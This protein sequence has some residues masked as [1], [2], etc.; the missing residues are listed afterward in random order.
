MSLTPRYSPSGPVLP[1]TPGGGFDPIFRQLWLDTTKAPGGNGS[2][3]TPYNTWAAAVA[4]LQASGGSNPWVIY[5]AQEL[6]ATGTP[7][8]NIGAGGH[9]TPLVKLQGTVQS[10]FYAP[11]PTSLLGLVISAQDGGN[12]ALEITNLSVVGITLPAGGLTLTGQD[13]ILSTVTSGGI[14]SGS[15]ILIDCT[16]N[17]IDLGAWSLRMAGGTVDQSI[18]V[19]S[20]FLDDVEFLDSSQFRWTS[21]LNLSNCRFRA[22]TQLLCAANNALNVDVDTW[23]SMVAAG[24]TFPD[25]FPTITITPW[26]PIMGSVIVVGT[27]NIAGGTVQNIDVGVIAPIEAEK[28]THCVVNFGAAANINMSIV[29]AF[30]DASR[31]LH[32]LVKNSNVAA[33][34]L[35][36]PNYSVVYLPRVSP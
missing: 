17:N 12:F 30:I 9:D 18:I 32:V 6:D 7:I 27:T 25:T 24:V 3:G 28:N 2:I 31:H 16:L 14:V 19:D 13:S 22:G 29:G 10:S 33:Q 1:I 20:G 21:S 35:I 36:D 23:G 15:S 4:P 5:L 8:P 11:A 26:V 34:D